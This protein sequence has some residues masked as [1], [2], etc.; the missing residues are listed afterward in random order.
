MPVGWAEAE[1]AGKNVDFGRG[2]AAMVYRFT[3]DQHR[4]RDVRRLSK[5]RMIEQAYDS[6]EHDCCQVPSPELPR[7]EWRIREQRTQRGYG[8]DQKYV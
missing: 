2:T 8:Q 4:V 6:C 1:L 5:T 7:A 3:F